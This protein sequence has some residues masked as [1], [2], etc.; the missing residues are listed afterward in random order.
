MNKFT[1]KKV[2]RKGSRGPGPTCGKVQEYN[3][4]RSGVVVPSVIR[5]KVGVVCVMDRV[6]PISRYRELPGGSGTPLLE[7]SPSSFSVRVCVDGE[8]SQMWYT[9]RHFPSRLRPVEGAFR[10]F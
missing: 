9:R 6:S 3:A 2:L 5:G 7:P 8:G 1:L 10:L 4:P